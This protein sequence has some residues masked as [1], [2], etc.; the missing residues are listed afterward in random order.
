MIKE[1]MEVKDSAIGDGKEKN[2]SVRNRKNKRKLMLM[3]E[4]AKAGKRGICYLS[5]VPPHMDP[6][7]LRQILS[8]YGEIQR[9]YL[10]P[11]NPDAQTNRKQ[12][13]GF[14]GQ[15]FTEGWVE[16]TKK[17]IA[18]RVAKMLNGQQMGGRKRSSFYYDIWNIK[19]LSKFKWDDLTEEIA[20]NNAVREQK[21]AL[22]LSA[23]TKERDFFL[24]QADKSRV[25]SAI[26]EKRL[27]KKQKVTEK[28]VESSDVPN[29]LHRPKFIRH[30]PQKAAVA[31]EGARESKKTR[32][33]KDTIAAVFGGS[34]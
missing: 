25:M 10:V 28:S 19:Y 32:L 17:S 24:S 12:A 21:L 30:F 1:D 9:I 18:K 16:F 22:E 15:E 34:S 5:R 29:N 14:R 2:G 20:Y 4:A 27:K 13:D 33:S 8:H 26:E 23:A 3:E 31:A 11:E 6:L 7:K